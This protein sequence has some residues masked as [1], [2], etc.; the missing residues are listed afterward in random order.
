MIFW[1]KFAQESVF[2]IK[3]KNWRSPMNSAHSNVPSFSLSKKFWILGPKFLQKG[4]FQS[5]TEKSHFT[6][7]I[8]L[9]RTDADR[10][11]S[12]LMTLLLLVAETII[13]ILLQIYYKIMN[14]EL[15]HFCK[16]LHFRCLAEFWMSLWFWY[17]VAWNMGIQWPKQLSKHFIQKI[18]VW[19]NCIPSSFE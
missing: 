5:K 2:G 6:Y 1:T 18:A 16:T 9:F 10:R 7:Y 11:N 4:Y 8:K 19:F 15:Y 13:K 12:I 3:W 17:C 14:F